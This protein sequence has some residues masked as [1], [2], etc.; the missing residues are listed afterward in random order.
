MSPLIDTPPDFRAELELWSSDRSLRTKPLPPGFRGLARFAGSDDDVD[1]EVAPAEALH[2]G[3]RGEVEVRF[4]FRDMRHD[5]AVGQ[6]FS[7]R[8]GATEIGC[9]SVL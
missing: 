9:G 1:V 7:L 6:S 4:L 2:P 8:E 3:Q 5:F